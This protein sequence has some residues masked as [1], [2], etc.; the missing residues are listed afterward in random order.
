[1]DQILQ[2]AKNLG[3][4]GENAAQ[5]TQALPDMGAVMELLQKGAGQEMQRDALLHALIPYLKPDR[6]RR[7]EKAMQL[8]RLSSLAGFALQSMKEQPEGE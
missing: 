8:A 1:M 2:I 3:L 7:L 5:P 6:R 4:G